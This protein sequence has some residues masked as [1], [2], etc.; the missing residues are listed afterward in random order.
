[1]K[2][3]LTKITS[4]YWLYH[5][6]I[7][8]DD[9]SPLLRQLPKIHL[10][11]AALPKPESFQMWYTLAKRPKLA[12]SLFAASLMRIWRFLDAEEYHIEIGSSNR[13]FVLD[14]F[15]S[16]GKFP[17]FAEQ[18]LCYSAPINGRSPGMAKCRNPTQIVAYSQKPITIPEVMYSHDYVA[19]ILKREP[20]IRCFDPVIGKGLLMRYAIRNGHACYGIEMNETRLQ[21]ADEYVRQA[22]SL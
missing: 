20:K 9:M 7:G 3:P 12:H 18:D 15:E 2:N 5:A 4:D 11:Y 14:F 16:W 6:E 13:Q 10:V 19:H 17:F 22:L 1:M 8:K 21:C